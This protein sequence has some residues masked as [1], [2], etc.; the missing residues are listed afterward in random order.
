MENLSTNN[1]KNAIPTLMQAFENYLADRKDLRITTIMSYKD[2]LKRA[3]SLWNVPIDQIK[4]SD[5]KHLYSSLRYDEGYKPASIE[6]LNSVL[7]PTFNQAVRDDIIVKNPVQG[8]YKEVARG[9]EWRSYHKSAVSAET[10]RCFLDYIHNSPEFRHWENFFIFLF[11]TGCRIGEAI[12]IRWEDIS[13]IDGEIHI[14]R[15][16][17][18]KNGKYYQDLPKTEAGIR[19]IPILDEVGQALVRES[20]VAKLTKAPIDGNVP[21]E[22]GL[23]FTSRKG[24]MLYASTVNNA[25]KNIIN[26]HNTEHP[27][28][29]MES[30][31]VHQIRHSFCTRLCEQ[32]VNVKVIQSVMGHSNFKTTMDIYAEVSEKKKV[33]VFRGLSGKIVPVDDRS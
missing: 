13:F 18:Y 12:A 25:I 19:T 26:R 24:K 15:S 9:R 20:Q 17:Y 21:G 5:I 3:E 6:L 28:R 10:Q 11:G 4:Y 27:D 30:F 33:D 32:D 7:L 14:N 22:K 23:I 16:V 8:V 31:S 2:S 29:P 1:Q